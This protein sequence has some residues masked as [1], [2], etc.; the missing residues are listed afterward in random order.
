MLWE[1]RLTYRTRL[2]AL[3]SAF[4]CGDEILEIN[5]TVV[6]DM[7]LNDVY[8]VL[9]RC[10]AGPVHVIVSRHPDPKVGCTQLLCCGWTAA[11]LTLGSFLCQRCRSSS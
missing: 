9:S 4:S 2:L 11:E 10:E 8:T 6:H 1:P 3:L 5:A 7:A